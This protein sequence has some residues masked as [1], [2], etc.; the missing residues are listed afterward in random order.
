MDAEYALSRSSL[1]MHLDP[2]AGSPVVHA[3]RPQERLRILAQAGDMLEVESTRW[4]PPLRGFVPAA[5]VVRSSASAAVFPQVELAA[6]IRIPTVPISLPLLSF[7]GWLETENESPWL[8]PSYVGAIQR[9]EQP[10]VGKSIRGIVG[11]QR[12]QWDAWVGEVAADARLDSA[13]LDEWIVRQQGGRDLW[14]IRAERVFTDPSQHASTLGWVVPEDVLRWTGRVR[15]NE[16]EPKYRLWYEVELIKADRL[17]RGWYKASLLDEFFAPTPQ[18]DVAVLQ[19]RATVFDLTRPVLRL[20]A[21]PEM[22]DA[23]KAG[24]LGAQYIDIRRALGSGMLHHNLCGPFCAA[25]LAGVDIIPLLQKWLSF[26]P[27][28]H[29]ILTR[30]RG[31]SIPDLQSTLDMFGVKHEFYRAVGSTSPI[32]PIY[33]RRKLDMGMTGIVFTGVTPY[34]V[35]SSR[36]PI[37]HWVVVEDILRVGSGGWV[38]LYNPFTNR[39]ETYLFEEV[40]DLP[41]RDSIGLWVQP[42]LPGA[43]ETAVLKVAMPQPLAQPLPQPTQA[44]LADQ[45]AVTV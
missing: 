38:R 6:G 35:V 15:N 21:D 43:S 24:R 34:G 13:T 16:R 36:S 3:L 18:T 22:D 28:A 31:T 19:N 12:A 45:D 27:R 5:A 17:L 30:D 23:R 14:S 29:E 9:G 32:T 41:A 8:P 26:Y 11:A 39:E 33:V 25:A 4:Q 1:D 42:R 7:I 10:S 2:A 44:V 40:F 37:R 20:P